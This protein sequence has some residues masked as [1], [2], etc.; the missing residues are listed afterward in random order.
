MKI[1]KWDL[2]PVKSLK[3][4]I[5]L[6]KEILEKVKQDRETINNIISWKDSRKLLII[7]PCSSDFPDS[8]VEYTTFLKEIS[9]KVS[10]KIF[11]IMRFYT[12]KPRTIWWWKGLQNSI[13]GE[14]ANIRTWIET[15]RKIWR[16]LLSIWLPL[17]DEILHP[18]IAVYYEDLLSYASIGSR[19]TRNQFHREFV[20]GLDYSVWFKNSMD[21]DVK[22]AL[23]W[24]IASSNESQYILWSHIY[25]TLWNKYSHWNLRWW[26]TW[27]NYFAK[28]MIE[29]IDYAKTN[30][31]STGFI[32]DCNHW[33]SWKDHLE[34]INILE[35]VLTKE[36]D[37]VSKK[38]SN[39]KD[40]IKWF[41]VES[42]LKDW[43]QDLSE[44]IEHWLS[45]TDSCIWL[46]NTKKLINKMYELL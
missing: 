23:E 22:I 37:I 2:P 29:Y 38:H 6:S 25:N 27:P 3:K 28:D 46:D 44:N 35:Q 43:R 42:Y 11:I 10:D 7:W 18:Q 19:N 9:D 16:E 26:S 20:S 40:L 41:M 15:I 32:I 4:R 14:K 34:Q 31:N 17:A 5:W 13:P 24:V 33:N 45:L 30:N 8:L 1:Y 12:G 39:A 21:W 36:L